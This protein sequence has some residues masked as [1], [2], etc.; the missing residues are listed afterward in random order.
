MAEAP[1]P[2]RADIDSA[3]P[4]GGAKRSWRE[5]FETYFHRRVLGMWFLGFSAGLPLL[6]VFSTLSLWL[7]ESGVSKASIGF[8]AWIGI[9][10]SVKVFWS[11]IVDQIRIPWLTRRLGQRRSWMLAGQIGIMAGL[12]GMALTDPQA[13]LTQIALFGV[14]VAFSSSTQDIAIDAYRIEAADVDYQAAMSAMYIFGYRIAMLVAGAGALYVAAGYGWEIAYLVMAALMLIGVIT[15]LIVAE[16][17]ITK[18]RPSIFSQPEVKAIIDAGAE[19]RKKLLRSRVPYLGKVVHDAAVA[20]AWIVGAVVSPFVDF[21]RRHGWIALAILGFIA[22][23]RISDLTMGI[24]AN[25]FYVALHYSKIDI[26]NV[27]KLF[28]L[29]MTLVGAGIGGLVV[30]RYGVMR[31]LLAGAVLVA[32]TNLCFAWMASM[33]PTLPLREMVTETF[34]QDPSLSGFIALSE[35]LLVWPEPPLWPL[36][37]TISLDNFAGG[38]ATSAFIAYLS[39]LTNTTYTA[40]QYALF[41]SLMTLAGKFISGWSGVVVEATG[42]PIFFLY[43]AATGLPAI[44]LVYFLIRRMNADEIKRREMA[45]AAKA[46]E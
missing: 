39:S 1:A 42:F 33:L 18:S 30:A 31:P 29:V 21:F 15:V 7:A 38:F 13:N 35:R 34:W 8:F 40:T 6:L 41:S 44:L 19:R 46:A 27:T 26:A 3:A 5:S 45:A 22:L 36:T 25:P 37:I 10:Y 14:L 20:Q 11:P 24:M 2:D 23:Y 32:L 9:T 12:A 43:A 4:P 17:E 28:G 16:P